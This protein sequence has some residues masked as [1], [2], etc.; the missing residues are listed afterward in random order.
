MS[1]RPRLMNASFHLANYWIPRNSVVELTRKMMINVHASKIL[2]PGTTSNIFSL[3]SSLSHLQF[4][5]NVLEV[6]TNS[7]YVT[8][9][10]ECFILMPFLRPSQYSLKTIWCTGTMDV[11]GSNQS[12]TLLAS[13]SSGSATSVV[14]K[15]RHVDACDFRKET[16]F[17]EEMFYFSISSNKSNQKFF[18][19]D[20]SVEKKHMVWCPSVKEKVT[21]LHNFFLFSCGPSLP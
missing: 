2:F 3:I 13:I 1:C 20:F 4:E 5:I 8:T 7:F 18:S 17:Y 14:N 16:Q 21:H 12:T 6:F 19:V 10:K 9:K 15:L 11:S